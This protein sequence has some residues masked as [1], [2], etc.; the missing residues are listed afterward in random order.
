[1]L[2]SQAQMAKLNSVQ[3]P[4]AAVQS[5]GIFRNQTAPPSS[6]TQQQP[7]QR[8]LGLETW[9]TP[10]TPNRQRRQS[11]GETL[12]YEI[13]A[14][15][16]TEYI[17]AIP[18]SFR[19]SMTAR[20]EYTRQPTGNKGVYE[21]NGSP[22]LRSYRSFDT[23]QMQG[24]AQVRYPSSRYPSSQFDRSY[25]ESYSPGGYM[26]D[27][28]DHTYGSAARNGHNSTQERDL[29]YYE[30]VDDSELQE[31]SVEQSG[32]PSPRSASTSDMF[33]NPLEIGLGVSI[34]A[35]DEN[36]PNHGAAR[37]SGNGNGRSGD[38]AELGE[39]RGWGRRALAVRG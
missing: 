17:S 25:L 4:D 30:S 20:T 33:I 22:G 19:Q 37:K 28:Y 21:L 7:T 10:P 34:G 18:Q 36:F 23:S 9:P 2:D 29:E 14:Q 5:A 31:L 1:M 3:V 8:D 11:S 6:S 35:G 38:A 26:G 24:H 13:K 16:S 32:L 12:S 15:S 27:E 39:R